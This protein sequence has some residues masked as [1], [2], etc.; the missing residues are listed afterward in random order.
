MPP[1]DVS[2]RRDE[3]IQMP[4]APAEGGANGEP[5]I[6]AVAAVEEIL[7]LRRAGG[8]RR[9]SRERIGSLVD[10]ETRRMTEAEDLTVETSDGLRALPPG[11]PFG[12]LIH[13]H[14]RTVAA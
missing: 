9:G 2:Q 7:A 13:L 6:A 11:Q 10:E 12:S 3:L 14:D 4:F 1:S 8:H 5:P